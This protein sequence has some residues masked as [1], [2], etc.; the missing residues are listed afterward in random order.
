[1]NRRERRS[2]EK[3]LGL[4]KHYKT[5]SKTAKFDLQAERI[6][7]GKQRQEETKEKIKQALTEQADALESK[8]IFTIAESIAANQKIPI[9]DAMEAAKLEYASYKK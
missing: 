8:Q 6:T 3:L 1:M 2:T 9:T 7:L 5:L 4:T